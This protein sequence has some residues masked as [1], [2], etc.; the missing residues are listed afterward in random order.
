MVSTTVWVILGIV[1]IP[2]Y[3][4]VAW[5]LFD[6]RANFLEA[7]R[8]LGTSNWISALRGEAVEDYW[9][10]MKLGVWVAGCAAFVV[11]EAWLINRIFG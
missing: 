11:G 1:N 5:V 3:I 4:A 2:V 8:F 7:L 9:E 6:T 10:T